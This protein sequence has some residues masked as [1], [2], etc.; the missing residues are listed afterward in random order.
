VGLHVGKNIIDSFPERSYPARII[1]LLNEHKRLGEKSG[2]GFYKYDARRRAAPDAD[3]VPL[4]QQSRK[5]GAQRGLWKRIQR[6]GAQRHER[7]HRQR[8]DGPR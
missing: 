3:L 6:V 5:V 1:Q 4:V 8:L 2:R 7:C